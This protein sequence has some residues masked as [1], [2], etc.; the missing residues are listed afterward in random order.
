MI[1]QILRVLV[2]VLATV[3]HWIVYFSKLLW[4]WIV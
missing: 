1:G 3:W 2:L 4:R